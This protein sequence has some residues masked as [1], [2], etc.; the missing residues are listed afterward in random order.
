[1]Y[2]D[3]EHKPVP[4]MLKALVTRARKERKQLLIMG[5]VNSHSEACWNSKDTNARGRAWETFISDKGLRVMNKGDRFT[6]ISSTGQ[7]IVDV[8]LA[9]P[10]LADLVKHWATVDYVPSSDHVLNEFMLLT[11]D[12]WTPRPA[13]YILK[14]CETK[15]MRG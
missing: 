3:I 10:G 4:D 7:S 12:C 11:D 5:D 2:C 8:T 13:G 14:D 6:Y 9:T 15:K 1:M